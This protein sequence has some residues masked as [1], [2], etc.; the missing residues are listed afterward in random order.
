MAVAS[1]PPQA[2]A[3]PKGMTYGR[4]KKLHPEL[5]LRQIR[6]L[7]ALYK[8]GKDLLRNKEVMDEIFPK[9]A[10]EQ[11]AVYE[12]MFALVV[13]QTSA[14][15]A[16]DPARFEPKKE[17]DEDE[18]D[19]GE[20][21]PGLPKPPPPAFA[22]PTPFAKKMDK[23]PDKDPDKDGDDDTST[24]PDKNPDAKEDVAQGVIPPQ[25]PPI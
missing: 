22:K 7:K 9:Y 14:G 23:D 21:P 11:D 8:G 1:P 19:L 3:Q 6:I 15:L 13:N 2:P 25:T 18:F 5:D 4:L 10:H 12:N 17:D 24:D 20:P 16:Q